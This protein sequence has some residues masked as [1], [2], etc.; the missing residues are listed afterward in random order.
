MSN[1]R[2]EVCLW[3]ILWHGYF[4]GEFQNIFSVFYLLFDYQMAKFVKV[5]TLKAAT[6]LTRYESLLLVGF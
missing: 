3:V 5:T 6:S 1:I 4:P 2:D